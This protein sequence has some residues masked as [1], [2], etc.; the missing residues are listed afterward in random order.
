MVLLLYS[1]Q[2][3][4]THQNLQNLD[5]TC[6]STQPMNNYD[7]AIGGVSVCTPVARRY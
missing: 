4:R 6:G 2:A 3:N 5:P 1:T 7:L